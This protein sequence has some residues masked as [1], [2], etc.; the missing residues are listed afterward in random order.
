MLE[1][2]GVVM[3]LIALSY[4]NVKGIDGCQMILIKLWK[5]ITFNN[6]GF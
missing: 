1:I 4:N 5:Y 2:H 3:S 6:I